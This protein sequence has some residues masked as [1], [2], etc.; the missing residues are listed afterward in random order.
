MNNDINDNYL[1]L[2]YENFAKETQNL[3]NLVKNEKDEKKNKE[4]HKQINI[5]HNI[6]LSLLK[7]RTLRNKK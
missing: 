3:L 4:L 7:L 2:S 6:E 1:T 5:I